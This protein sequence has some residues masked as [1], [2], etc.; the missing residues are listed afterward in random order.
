MWDRIFIE[1]LKVGQEEF[2]VAI[3]VGRENAM[4]AGFGV[5]E[6]RTLHI[7]FSIC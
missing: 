1:S 2:I 4:I 5:Y 3:N 7:G 6:I